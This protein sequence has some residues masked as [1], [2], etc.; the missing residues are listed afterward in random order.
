MSMSIL[1]VKAEPDRVYAVPAGEE[2]EE[3]NEPALTTHGI[4]AIDSHGSAVSIQ[5]LKAELLNVARTFLAEVES[6]PDDAVPT[7]ENE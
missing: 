4:A 7:T 1:S 3:F 5:G 6:L 2:R